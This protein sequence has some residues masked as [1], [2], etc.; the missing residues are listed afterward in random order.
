MQ[1]FHQLNVWR[2][3]H[4]LVLDVYTASRNLPQTETMGLAANL[5]RSA[6]T[7]PRTIAE[8]TGRASDFEFANDLKRSRAAAHELE[9]MLLLCRDLGFLPE[10]VHDRLLEDLLEVRRMISGLVNRL[11]KTPAEPLP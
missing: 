3:A 10:L 6:V 2:K 8:G 7:I 4:S 5:R 9:Y 1:D 11:N